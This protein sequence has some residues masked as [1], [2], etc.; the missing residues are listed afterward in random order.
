[1]S[2]LKITPLAIPDV[3]VIEPKKFGD[4]R[5]FFSETYNARAFADAGIDLRFVQDNHSYSA[6]PG[7]L[8]GLHYQGA[9]H[10]QDKLVRVLRGRILDVAVDLRRSSPTFGKWVSAEI[11]AEAWNQILV[12]AGFAHAILTLEPHTELLYKVSN[13]YAP[14]HDFGIRWNDPELAIDWPISEDKVIL[15]DKDAKQPFL[16]DVA[17]LFD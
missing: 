16:K 13:Y 10:A 2:N 12:P 15:S 3:L 11:S 17:D 4:H 7:T 14:S 9:P 8:R 6:E 1:M 5:G